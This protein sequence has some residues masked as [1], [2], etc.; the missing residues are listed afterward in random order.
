MD[1]KLVL[2][3]VKFLSI[4]IIINMLKFLFSYMGKRYAG[5]MGGWVG[6]WFI[7]LISYGLIDNN[8]SDEDKATIADMITG[9]GSGRDKRRRVVIAAQIALVTMS[10][11]LSNYV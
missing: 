5:W 9:G 6:G 3:V 8:I 7:G 4:I 1:S 10:L 2:R 11:V